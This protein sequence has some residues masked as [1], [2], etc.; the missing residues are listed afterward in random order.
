[1]RMVLITLLVIALLA[2]AFTLAWPLIL[3]SF[4]YYPQRLTPEAARPE[5]SGLS[6]TAEVWITTADGVRLHGWWT[7]ADPD[8]WPPCD[9][10]AIYFHGNAGTIVG[11][12]GFARALARVGL[13]VLLFDYRGY[14]LSEGRPSERGLRADADAAWRFLVEERGRSPERVILIGNSLG[15][16]VAARLALERPAAGLIMGA[17]F[18]DFPSAVRHHAPWLPVS[19]LRWTDGRYEAGRRIDRVGM[20]V[21]ILA[22]SRDTLVPA[23]LSEQVFERAA[24]PKR[25]VRVESDHNTLMGHPA[26]WVAIGEFLT[27]HLGCGG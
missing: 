17:P 6:T 5:R 13:D 14:G 2:A 16:A 3:R 20:P 24:R 19:L 7:P 21:L 18:P 22:G 27:E 25:L 12:A 9:A 11:R 26:S 10:A 15:S 23:R 4:T 8:G 1:M